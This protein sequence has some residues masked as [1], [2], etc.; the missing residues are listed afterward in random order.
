[1]YL[2][3]QGEGQLK[4]WKFWIKYVYEVVGYCT[5]ATVIS[6]NHDLTHSTIYLHESIM[7]TQMTYKGGTFSAIKL[8]QK[9]HVKFE[10][11]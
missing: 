6:T 9:H 5:W 2:E 4:V 7:R 8:I 11:H 3:R 10:E 1:M